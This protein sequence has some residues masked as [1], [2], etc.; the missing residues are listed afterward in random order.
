MVKIAALVAKAVDQ[1]RARRELSQINGSAE[2]RALVV[3]CSRRNGVPKIPSL[4]FPI[5]SSFYV[6]LS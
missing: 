6:A 2:A 5:L 3:Q 4:P 1:S